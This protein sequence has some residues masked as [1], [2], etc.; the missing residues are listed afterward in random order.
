MRFLLIILFTAAVAQAQCPNG[1]CERP[2]R[3]IAR[4]LAATCTCTNCQ[5]AHAA[6]SH[7]HT[8]RG[9]VRRVLFRG[10]LFRRCR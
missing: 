5:C 4:V 3:P 7:A 1:V 10:W 6:H 2:A 8:Y 9:P